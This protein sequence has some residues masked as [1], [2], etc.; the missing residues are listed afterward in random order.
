MHPNTVLAILQLKGI[1]SQAEAVKLAEFVAQA[2]QSTILDDAVHSVASVLDKIEAPI[3]A[4]EAK[5]DEAVAA[6]SKAKGK[7]KK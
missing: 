3:K 6:D 4:E 1:I 7:S 5:I 2:P